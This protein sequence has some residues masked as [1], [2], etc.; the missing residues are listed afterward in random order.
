VQ[1]DEEEDEEEEGGGRRKK[2]RAAQFF[3]DIAAVDDD[4]EEDEADVS[5]QG[6]A[7]LNLGG[8]GVRCACLAQSGRVVEGG[9][10]RF[11]ASTGWRRLAQF[12]KDIA[13]VDDDE[14]DEE[15]E[16]DVI[17]SKKFQQGRVFLGFFS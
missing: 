11:F 16:A 2:S 13:A 15:D 5:Q 14:E 4:E 9:T 10:G 17:F 12:F 8:P 6:L 7:F 1:E 3:D